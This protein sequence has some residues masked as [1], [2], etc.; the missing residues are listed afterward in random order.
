MTC[1]KEGYGVL[2]EFELVATGEFAVKEEVTQLHVG[3]VFA[4]VLDL[5]AP[6]DQLA[7]VP[8]DVC[9]PA[10]AARGARKP[11]VEREVSR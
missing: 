10:D 5:V 11:R 3:A 4:K 8:V 6:V 9:D 2:E 7:L 1:L